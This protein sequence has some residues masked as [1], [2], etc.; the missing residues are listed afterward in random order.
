MTEICT[1]TKYKTRT[2][3]TSCLVKGF[4]SGPLVWISLLA[5]RS[6]KAAVANTDLSEDAN[7]HAIMAQRCSIEAQTKIMLRYV[8]KELTDIRDPYSRG[9]TWALAKGFTS[10]HSRQDIYDLRMDYGHLNLR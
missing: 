2:Q 4:V 1:T 6:Q 10:N 9:L 3:H 5:L 7:L 8:W